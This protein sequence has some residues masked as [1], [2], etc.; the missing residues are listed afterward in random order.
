VDAAGNRRMTILSGPVVAGQLLAIDGAVWAWGLL[1]IPASAISAPD[2][3]GWVQVSPEAALVDA[4]AGQL[5]TSI[6]APVAPVYAVLT[7]S[8]R[9][10]V[11]IPIAD[12]TFGD[13]ACPA[14]RLDQP[15]DGAPIVTI[16]GID[17]SGLVCGVA[18]T[19][20]GQTSLG[21]WTFGA[22]VDIAPPT[23]TPVPPIP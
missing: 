4:Q 2:A 19:Y 9:A 21:I 12:Q 8:E 1:P 5:V 10:R 23:G 7:A 17:G 22:A 18:I 13:R 14:W 20:G 3:A 11:A 6:L 15:N 16:I